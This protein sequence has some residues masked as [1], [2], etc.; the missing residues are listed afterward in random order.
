[1]E[2]IHIMI[3]GGTGCTSGKS[4]LVKEEFE[5]VLTEK[6]SEIRLE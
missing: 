2:K 5:K 3:C 1:M 4:K 6:E